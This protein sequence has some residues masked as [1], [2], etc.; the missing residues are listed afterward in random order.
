MEG[1]VEQQIEVG[2]AGISVALIYVI[3]AA[4]THRSD[5]LRARLD[6]RQAEIA[7]RDIAVSVRSRARSGRGKGR[8]YRLAG[9]ADARRLHDPLAGPPAIADHAGI[10]RADA[11]GVINRRTKTGRYRRLGRGGTNRK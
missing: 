10:G 9:P 1:G 3:I 8:G 11:L 2:R 5:R 4:D 6:H 7:E